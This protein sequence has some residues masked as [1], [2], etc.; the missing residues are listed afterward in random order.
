MPANRDG[1]APATDET[2]DRTAIV[3]VV[4]AVASC[5]DRH[6]WPALRACFH[7]TVTVDYA[8]LSGEP[9][10]TVPA[11][12]L[13]AQWRGLLPGFRATHHQ[14]TNHEVQVEGD[15]ASCRAHVRASHSLP[16]GETNRLWVVVGWYDDRLVRAAGRWRVAAITLSVSWT[17]GD[18]DLPR[19]AAERVAA[20]R[21]TRERRDA[22]SAPR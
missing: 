5:A 4:S 20:E 13:I 21:E 1:P 18:A 17:E 19:L 14:V 3:E 7:D 2:G 16:D 10:A 8:A 6:E 12:D 22:G 11:D 15:A 9:A